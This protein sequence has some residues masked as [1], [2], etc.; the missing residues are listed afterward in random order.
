[1]LK[2]FADDGAAVIVG[3][4]GG[5]G[6]ALARRIAASGRFRDVIGFSRNGSPPLDLM[7]E[8]TIRSAVLTLA[9]RPLRL[10]V[11][12]TGV[13]HDSDIVPEKTVRDLSPE[14]MS[15]VLAINTVGP[16]LLMKHLLPLLPRQGKAV[17]AVLSAKVG[18]ISD[19]RLGGWYSYRASKAALNQLVRTAAIELGR[20]HPDAACVA[21]HPGTVATDLSAPFAKT[22][23]HVQ[24]PDQAADAL[25]HCLDLIGPAQSG[26][27]LDR[28]GAALPW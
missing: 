26:A 3:A 27:F 13:L 2:S 21:L 18:S 23:L 1:M 14:S 7:N 5:I 28:S 25:L 17:F 22:G 24:K 10:A 15:R 11:V 8:D 9:G 19:N 4:T 20:T 12:A 6:G 16:A